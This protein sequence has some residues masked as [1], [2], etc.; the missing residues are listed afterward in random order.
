LQLCFSALGVLSPVVPGATSKPA[1]R[2]RCA[3]IVNWRRQQ[4]TP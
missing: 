1:A 2:A 4:V 3:E